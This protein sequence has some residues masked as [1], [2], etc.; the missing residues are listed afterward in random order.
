MR[1][2]DEQKFYGVHA[3][4]ALFAAR[5]GDIV[6]AY[7]TNERMP[8]FA[9]LM[10]WC[11][12]NKKAY[13]IVTPAEL[14]K[15][16]SSVHHEGVALLAKRHKRLDDRALVERVVALPEAAADVMVYLD[17]VQNPHNIGSILR[18]AAHFGAG[19]LLGRRG[20]L[21]AMSP[22]ACRV[23]EGGAERVPLADLGAAEATLKELK[24]Q[25]YKLVG[26]SSHGGDGVFSGPLPRRA[27][28]VLGA[29]VTGMSQKATSLCDVSVQ[30]PGTGAVESLN[31]AMAAGILLAEHWRAHA[32]A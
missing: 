23:A 31:V 20:E 4:Q 21:P 10:K 27:V 9:D 28:L 5:A 17:G 14:E 19:A 2:Q 13:H 15:I 16:V 24:A 12:R 3:C 32:K 7:V 26:T 6:R 29:E 30:I 18:V 8:A 11:A 1:T 25:G 22:S